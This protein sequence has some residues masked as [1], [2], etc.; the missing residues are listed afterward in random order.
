MTTYAQVCSAQVKTLAASSLRLLFLHPKTLVDSWPFPVDT[1]GEI[2]KFPSAVYPVLAATIADL[3]VEARIFDGYVARETFAGYKRRLRWPDVIAITCMS[4][5]KALDTELT[6][7]LANRINPGVRIVVGGNHASAWPERWLQAGA[8]FVVVGEGE[9][10]FRRLIEALL[11]EVAD[12]SKIPS[13]YW[14]EDCAIHRST[15]PL[16]A[17]ALDET[18]MPDWRMMDLRPYGMGLSNGLA[19]AVE[20]SRGCPHRCDFCNINT[21]WGHRQ[22]YKSVGRVIAELEVLKANGITEFIITDDNFG[23]NEKHTI[24]LLQEMVRRGLDMRFGCL[25]RGDTVARNAAFAPLAAQAGMRFCLMGIETLDENWLRQHRK[26]VRSADASG[27]YAR[28]YQQLSAHDI[29]VVGLFICPPSDTH[30][31]AAG[32]GAAGVVCDY[33]MSAD[34]L[35]SKGSALYD[36]ASAAGKVSKDMFYHDW[37]LTS[38]VLDSG[39]AQLPQ[40]SGVDLIKENATWFT[41]RQA[42]FKS[43]LSRRFWLRPWMIGLERLLCMTWDDWRRVRIARR[44]DLTMQQR[45]DLI[46]QTVLSDDF[47]DR[48]ARRRRWKSP[49]ALRTGLWSASPSRSASVRRATRAVQAFCKRLA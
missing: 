42:V 3:P 43:A 18:A 33:R 34:L 38:M 49:L 22:N 5:M 2:V 6:I 28:V 17:L 19:V 24:A 10:P 13:L 47:I 45:Q 21:F 9:I 46:V 35:A 39:A 8:D 29:F 41:L 16:P 12:Y 7:K 40:G 15:A 32:L 1:L 27:M 31:A 48:L 36:Q 37:S 23:G 25:L 44:V 30:G 11:A 4:P 20:I 14:R 26:G